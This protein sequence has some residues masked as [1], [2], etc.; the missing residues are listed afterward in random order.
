VATGHQAGSQ[1]AL[2][3]LQHPYAWRLDHGRVTLISVE[4]QEG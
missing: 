1:G 4:M 3:Q 2:F